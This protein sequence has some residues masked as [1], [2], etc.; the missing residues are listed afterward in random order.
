[1]C[2]GSPKWKEREKVSKRGIEEIKAENL[3]DFMRDE[4]THQES[5]QNPSGINL[6]TSTSWHIITKLSKDKNRI[7]KAQERSD[8]SHIRSL[9]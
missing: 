7:L 1:M 4:S 9:Q 6:R 5:Q 8:S 3:P 2:G